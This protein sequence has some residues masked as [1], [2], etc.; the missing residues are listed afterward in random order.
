MPRE[1]LIMICS[2]HLKVSPIVIVPR[3][4]RRFSTENQQSLEKIHFILKDFPRIYEKIIIFRSED[5]KII[6]SQN[7][8][9]DLKILLGFAYK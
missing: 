9:K 3:K 6:L 4:F 1:C 2:K 7:F 5:R 8:L